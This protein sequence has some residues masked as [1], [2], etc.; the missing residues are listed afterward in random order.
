MDTLFYI[1]LPRRSRL[2]RRVVECPSIARACAPP[3]SMLLPPSLRLRVRRVVLSFSI[4]RACAP[5]SSILLQVRSS[6]R[7]RRVVESFSAARACA[8]A[9]QIDD[10]ICFL[11]RVTTDPIL[12]PLAREICGGQQEQ[13]QE[14]PSE[15][16]LL[17]SKESYAGLVALYWRRGDPRRD[18][19][20]GVLTPNTAEKRL[21]VNSSEL[22][23]PLIIRDI[24]R[25]KKEWHFMQ[26]VMKV[27]L[28]T[29]QQGDTIPR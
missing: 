5:A 15:N 10:C 8:P 9:S 16:S 29:L 27:K 13:Q 2:C 24:A 12:I 14:E 3:E 4:A 11:Y 19:H 18:G 17:L 25:G 26:H 7:V 23:I 22:V 21:R 1:R 28:C 6:V 20:T